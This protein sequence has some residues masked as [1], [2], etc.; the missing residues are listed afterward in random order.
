M[1]D[2]P[3]S[4]FFPDQSRLNQTL[5]MAGYRLDVAIQFRGYIFDGYSRFAAD[6]KKNLNPSVVRNA[7]QMAL[8]LFWRFV[9]FVLFLF[10]YRHKQKRC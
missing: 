10:I 7:F 4:I 5:G 6:K 3:A 9:C 8:Q 2:L 1:G